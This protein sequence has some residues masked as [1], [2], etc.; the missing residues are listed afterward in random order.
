MF[1]PVCV[2]VCDREAENSQMSGNKLDSRKISARILGAADQRALRFPPLAVSSPPRRPTNTMNAVQHPL[3][4]FFAL[5]TNIIIAPRFRRARW[6]V[7]GERKQLSPRLWRTERILCS[8]LITVTPFPSDRTS[9]PIHNLLRKETIYRRI[10]QPPRETIETSV[11][12]VTATP[13]SCILQ[14]KASQ[15][16]L[17][18]VA[19]FVTCCWC[20][21][22]FRCFYYRFNYYYYY[23]F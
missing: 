22:C 12:Y 4:I 19:Y 15:S 6:L 21:R 17:I 23:F 9:G 5:R 8:L 16:L 11:I 13:N 10:P 7:E 14:S 2:C 20:C 18:V 3:F 1:V